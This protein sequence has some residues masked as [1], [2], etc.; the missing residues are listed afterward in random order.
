MCCGG[1]KRPP[2]HSLQ[3]LIRD[4]HAASIS[5]CSLTLC[6][7]LPPL[8]VVFTLTFEWTPHR[9]GA[10]ARA[11]PSDS[12]FL[13]FSPFLPPSVFLFLSSARRYT[14]RLKRAPSYRRTRKGST[15]KALPASLLIESIGREL[16]KAEYLCSPSPLHRLH[17]PLSPH[18]ARQASMKQGAAG[19]PIM[20]CG[21]CDWVWF[22]WFQMLLRRH[23]AEKK[24]QL[25]AFSIDMHKR[26]A[27]VPKGK[28]GGWKHPT[29]SLR[30]NVKNLMFRLIDYWLLF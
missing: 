9:R 12:S 15:L 25:V 3:T 21:N 22:K 17:P 8:C 14:K 4:C 18:R 1:Y 26:K 19:M 16:D 30:S 7:F 6:I 10:P 23:Q 2:S 28:W 11:V 13:S 29:E 5:C 27:L 20:C 24:K